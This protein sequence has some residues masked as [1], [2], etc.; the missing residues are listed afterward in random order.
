MGRTGSGKTQQAAWLLSLAA[1]DRQPYIIVDYKGDDLLNAI[2]RVDEIRLGEVPKHPGVYIVHPLPHETDETNE[3]LWK[4]WKREKTG[5]YFD[6]MYNV[7]DP[8]KK[9]ALRAILTQGRSKRIPAICLTQRPAWV[10]RFIFSEAD[11]Y[12]VFHLNTS[13]DVS[14]VKEFMP[15]DHETRLPTYNSQWYDVS[16]DASFQLLPAPDADT[17]LQRFDDRLAP[18]RRKF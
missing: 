4:I 1:F 8:Q 14:R 18:K 10:S 11:H 2:E 13:G 17:I 3:W 15:G 9:S 16:Q 12:S 7:P 6:E 5:L